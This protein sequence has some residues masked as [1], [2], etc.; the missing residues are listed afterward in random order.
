MSLSSVFRA[1]PLHVSTDS[2]TTTIIRQKSLVHPIHFVT[3]LLHLHDSPLM[4]I[5]TYLGVLYVM[6]DG[7]LTVD[8]MLLLVDPTHLL[9]N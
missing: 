5:H 1:F 8:K 7:R 3:N 6:N 9:I 2:A 4:D